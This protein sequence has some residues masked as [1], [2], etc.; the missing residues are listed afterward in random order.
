MAYEL[1][2]GKLVDIGTPSVVQQASM[3]IQG[4][5]GMSG[6]PAAG[7]GPG[8]G[9]EPAPWYMP[10]PSPSGE[11]LQVVESGGPLA[12]AGPLLGAA[13]ITLPTAITALLGAIGVGYAG[14][15]A[16]GGGEGGGIGG[17][18][19][20]GGDEGFIPGTMV[21][22]GGPGLPEPPA[23]M[24]AK[25]WSTGTAQ[26]YMLI[27]GRIAVYS[28]KKKRWK[29]Y[30][31]QK[32]AVIGKNLPSHR[33][34]VRLRHN[35]KRHKDDAISIIKMVAPKRLEKTHTRSQGPWRRK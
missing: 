29:I 28:K 31:P 18:N 3:G 34:L 12:L 10:K 20:L 11:P 25:E 16:L 4:M 26:F 30:R 13:G 24:V 32:M 5:M 23:A 33:T 7:P 2:N 8:T 9:A 21:P 27:D 6:V 22:L 14:Y 15:Q 17:L 1:R 19:I 35:L